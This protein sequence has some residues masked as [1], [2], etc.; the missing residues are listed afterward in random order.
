MDCCLS[1][2]MYMGSQ[3]GG[4]G[5][6]LSLTGTMSMTDGSAFIGGMD[7]TGPLSP[8]TGSFMTGGSITG[9]GLTAQPL[10]CSSVMEE[11]H[12]VQNAIKTA[13]NMLT[14]GHVSGP[15][16]LCFRKTGTQATSGGH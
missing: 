10:R 1:L 11:L 2:Q 6:S 15:A 9:L 4:G 12:L 13:K 16:S 8:S 5:D 14:K 3:S 7:T